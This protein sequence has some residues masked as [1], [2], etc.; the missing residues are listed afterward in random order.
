MPFGRAYMHNS[1]RSSLKE[2]MYHHK[3]IAFERVAN[4]CKSNASR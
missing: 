3:V 4:V 1:R 2:G